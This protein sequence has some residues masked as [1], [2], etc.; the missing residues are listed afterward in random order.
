MLKNN[1]DNNEIN[2]SEYYTS[3][4]VKNFQPLFNID[5]LFNQ[6][7]HY[8]ILIDNYLNRSNIYK[9]KIKIIEFNPIL[10]TD[11]CNIVKCD[12][13]KIFINHV[14]Y[15]DDNSCGYNI[16][17]TFY[18]NRIIIWILPSNLNTSK[19]THK[20]LGNFLHLNKTSLPILEK[21]NKLYINNNYICFL[22]IALSAQFHC[23]HFHILQKQQIYERKYP[24]Q[25]R[26]TVIIQ[27]HYLNNIINNIKI[28]NNYYEKINYNILKQ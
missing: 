17:E 25:D 7:I 1:K 28:N 27:E 5:N 21:I 9:D 10:L 22:H 26:G 2:I 20:Y 15:D 19:Q 4:L 12:N 18:D 14:Y 16:I 11:N 6:S 8:P 23:L 13:D 24:Y 3:E